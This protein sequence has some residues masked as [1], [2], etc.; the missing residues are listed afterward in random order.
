MKN[1]QDIAHFCTERLTYGTHQQQLFLTD[2]IGRRKYIIIQL[3][4]FVSNLDVGAVAR[5]RCSHV[6]ERE[7]LLSNLRSS[8][9]F[10][11]FRR[12]S[13]T[14]RLT[15]GTHQRHPMYNFFFLG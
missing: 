14:E 15:S 13:C 9:H 4:R 8:V 7:V 6:S 10:C 11:I 12:F 2:A 1:N 5:R 3:V